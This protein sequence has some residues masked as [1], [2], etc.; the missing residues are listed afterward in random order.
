MCLSLL[1]LLFYRTMQMNMI[2]SE[3]VIGHWTHVLFRLNFGIWCFLK[4]NKKK[5]DYAFE[6]SRGVNYFFSCRMNLIFVASIFINFG[7]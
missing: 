3:I 2:E 6:C 1:S 4:Q 5:K 7:M